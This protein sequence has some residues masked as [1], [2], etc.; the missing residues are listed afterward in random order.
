MIIQTFS[1]NKSFQRDC[2]FKIFAKHRLWHQTANHRSLFHV[3][4]AFDLCFHQIMKEFWNTLLKTKGWFSRNWRLGRC[5]FP[6]PKWWSSCCKMFFSVRI[7]YD[8]PQNG[9]KNASCEGGDLEQFWS[10]VLHGLGS[11]T[12]VRWWIS[13]IGGSVVSG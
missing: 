3:L 10:I 4:Y 13:L 7:Y 12:L 5:C 2:C 8:F 1:P 6:F 11:V 9:G